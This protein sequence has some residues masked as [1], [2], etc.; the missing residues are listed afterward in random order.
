MKIKIPEKT[1]YG[2]KFTSSFNKDLKKIFK[3]GKDIKK[4]VEVVNKLANGEKLDEKYKNHVLIDNKYY[5]GCRECHIEPDWL[6]IYKYMGDDEMIL[7]L[8]NTGSHSNLFIK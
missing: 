8:I 6:L 1:K 3:Q 4:L 7:L 2:I 5:K